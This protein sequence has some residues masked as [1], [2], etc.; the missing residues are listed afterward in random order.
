MLKTLDIPVTA[1]FS[2]WGARR[3]VPGGE[4]AADK[5]R[6]FMDKLM[7]NIKAGDWPRRTWTN[8]SPRRSRRRSRA[9]GSPRRRAA[10][11][12]W[13]KI[14]DTKIGNYQCVVPTT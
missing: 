14:K 11:A 7:A 5:M 4:W 3:P 12:H 1:L 9:S 6:Y 2:T 8:R 10:L 13:I